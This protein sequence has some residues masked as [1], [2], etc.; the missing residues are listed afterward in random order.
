MHFKLKNIYIYIYIDSLKYKLNKLFETPL[1]DFGGVHL[2]SSKT[3][4]TNNRFVP[5]TSSI[6]KRIT[7]KFWTYYLKKT[8]TTQSQE[9]S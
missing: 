4:S 8:F 3:F 1:L 9:L 2:A 5:R 6:H 7:S